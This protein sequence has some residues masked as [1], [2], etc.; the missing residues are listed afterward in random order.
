MIITDFLFQPFQYEFFTRAIIVSILIGGTCGLLGV[1]IVLRGMSYIG[2]GMS[3]AV[4]GGA[5]I[6][7]IVGINFYIGAAIW[8]VL[9]GLLITEI[10]KRYKI[11]ADA[12]IGVV[13][14]AGFAIGVFLMNTGQTPL[15][16]FEA[17]LFGNILAVTDLDF[18][19]ILIVSIITIT[20]IFFFQK[21]LLFTIFDSETA[22]VYGVK[23]YRVDLLFSIILA[24][25]VIAAMNS[26]GVTLLA[27]A[28]IAPAISARLIT[29]NFFKILVLSSV[30]GITNAYLGMYSSFYIDSPSGATIVLFGAAIFIIAIIYS[31]IKKS[32]HMHFHGD[33]KHSHP[34]SH[35]E[36]HR[37]EH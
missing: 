36:E 18:I 21:R 23:T 11:K 14:T 19:F 2:H 4:F 31:H 28:I 1:Y 27:A 8:G 6:S 3:H 25:V 5:V 29:N 12:A 17:L 20:F 30:I 33:K 34:H 32:Y 26:I 37:H 15:R 7:N 13:T 9:S 22:K 24:I 10:N 16:N 35:A